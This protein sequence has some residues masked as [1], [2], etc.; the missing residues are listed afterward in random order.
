MKLV[1]SSSLMKWSLLKECRELTESESFDWNGSEISGMPIVFVSHRWCKSNHP[2]GI[3]WV[4][5]ASDGGTR[6]EAG[7]AAVGDPFLGMRRCRASPGSVAACWEGFACFRDHELLPMLPTTT[8]WQRCFLAMLPAC[9][10]AAHSFLNPPM[11]HP[12]SALPDALLAKPLGSPRWHHR[13][14]T[15]A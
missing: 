3:G 2:V 1:R 5:D 15:P 12:R 7:S 14:G 13:S 8:L 9:L 4:Q 11:T 10:L 6:Q